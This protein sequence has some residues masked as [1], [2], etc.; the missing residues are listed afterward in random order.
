MALHS[1][2][3]SSSWCSLTIILPQ[4]SPWTF[5][6]DGNFQIFC[7]KRINLNNL[8]L[9]QIQLVTQHSNVPQIASIARSPVIRCLIFFFS[10][11]DEQSST[12]LTTRNATKPS[13]HQRERKIATIKFLFPHCLFS[14]VALVIDCEA[15]PFS[16]QPK[17]LGWDVDVC[18]SFDED[19]SDY[20]RSLFN[21]TR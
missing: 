13:S 1:T 16:R 12:T 6:V 19:D 17:V 14:S 18:V 4:S 11:I 7:Y 9:K 10:F 3:K 8:H 15:T 2:W 21:S 5:V 20:F